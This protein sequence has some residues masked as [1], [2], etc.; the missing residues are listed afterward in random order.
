L[1]LCQLVKAV[2]AL[3]IDEISQIEGF[4]AHFAAALWWQTDL[5]L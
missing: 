2:I 4:I 1:I 3:L 5:T